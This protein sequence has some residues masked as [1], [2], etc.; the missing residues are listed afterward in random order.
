M[1]PAL[2]LLCVN[3]IPDNVQNSNVVM[4][5]DDSKCCK[6]VKSSLDAIA[7]QEDLNVLG[8]WSVINEVYF[9]P[10]KCE[11]LRITRKRLRFERKNYISSSEEI[12]TVSHQRDLG[13]D[14]TSDL[15]RNMHIDSISA[16]AN[17]MLGFLRRTCTKDLAQKL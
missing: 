17:K 10:K 7:L 14:V 12:M 2:F 11:N 4:F 1:G 15:S 9:H 13:I 3:D 16:K 5:A 8:Q 6:T